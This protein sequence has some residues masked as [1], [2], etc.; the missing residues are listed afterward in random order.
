MDKEDYEKVR[1]LAWTIY[2]NE[3][4]H[5]QSFYCLFNDLCNWYETKLNKA[6]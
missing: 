3:K 6:T 2:C 4:D 1:R 5:E